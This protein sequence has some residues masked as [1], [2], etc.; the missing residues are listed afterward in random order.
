MEY[1]VIMD[2][3]QK[4]MGMD[5][6][7]TAICYFDFKSTDSLLG[8]KYH[9]LYNQG[10]DVFDG[11]KLFLVDKNKE[12]IVYTNEP[13]IYQVNSSYFVTNSIYLIK[14][15]LPEFLKDTSIVINRQNDTLINEEKNY[16]F[17]LSIKDRNRY[18]NL[19]AMITE[20]Q[21]DIP[22][23]SLY[24]SKK[25]YLPTQFI[26]V[27]KNK[28][29]WKASFSNISLSASRSDSIWEYNKFPQ[30]YLR[31]SNRE[32]AESMK[33]KAHIQVGQ[34]APNWSLPLVAGDSIQLSDLKGSLIVLEFWFPY[35]GGCV[36]AT[37]EINTIQ[38]IYS[39]KN[40][41]V[42][43]IEFTQSDNKRLNDYI[44]KQGIEYPTLY[45]GREVAKDYGVNAAPTFFLI[46][47]KG[48]IVYSSV[49]L[50]KDD[51]IKAI[52]DYIQ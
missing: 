32:F 10:E 16:S 12:L 40:L 42:Y 30:E 4:E 44:R 11:K 50:N 5:E 26:Y 27:F 22:I 31:M 1:Q 20:G 18:R 13:K 36:K 15:L 24:I 46:D 49:G 35:C 39:N 19:G 14:K 23:Y 41:K 17:N 43:G 25:S 28:G 47:K 7:D 9:F 6:I 34:N 29:Y 51:L 2:I 3:L 33:A 21:G 52:N 38:D 37:P 8:V 45:K 48:I